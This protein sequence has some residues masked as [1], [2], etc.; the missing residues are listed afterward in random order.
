MAQVV[1]GLDLEGVG[2]GVGLLLAGEYLER[3]GARVRRFPFQDYVNLQRLVAAVEYNLMPLQYNVFVY[4]LLFFKETLSN[5]EKNGLQAIRNEQET[6][7]GNHTVSHRNP[8]PA[9][10]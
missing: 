1:R 8:A 4:L 7:D 2:E 9:S 10:G 6:D 3:F 5:S